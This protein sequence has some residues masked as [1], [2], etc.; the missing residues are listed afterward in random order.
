MDSVGLFCVFRDVALELVSGRV[1]TLFFGGIMQDI[2]VSLWHIGF[3]SKGC[4]NQ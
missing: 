2:P 4:Q 3:V 1:Q